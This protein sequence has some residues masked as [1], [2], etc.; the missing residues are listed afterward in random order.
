ME[1]IQ[2]ENSRITD[3]YHSQVKPAINAGLDSLY[4]SLSAVSDYAVSINALFP[5]I[6]GTLTGTVSA[7]DSLIETL[8]QSG[9]M[10]TAG[11]EKL[12]RIIGEMEKISESERLEKLIELMKN[13]PGTMG[14]NQDGGER[15]NGDN[16]S[17]PRLKWHR[18]G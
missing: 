11:Q 5:Q 2:D 10:V 14:R 17:F 18:R 8:D 9:K 4:D 7:F 3:E 6:D 16:S 1:E 15:E 13:D 12:D